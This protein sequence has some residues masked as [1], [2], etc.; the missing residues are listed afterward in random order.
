MIQRGYERR[1]RHLWSAI[2]WQ[3]Y[4]LMQAQA[5][6]EALRKAGIKTV[7]DLIT[8]PWDNQHRIIPTEEEARQMQEE[9][10]AINAA[11]GLDAWL[12]KN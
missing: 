10:A 6:S 3:T 1:H 9:M 11:G 2:R 7:T 4:N 8:F 12:K 5:G